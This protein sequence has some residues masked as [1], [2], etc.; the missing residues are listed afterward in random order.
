MRTA[1]FIFRKLRTGTDGKRST[2][3]VKVATAAVALSVAVMIAAISIVGG[4]KREIT[5]RIVGFNSHLTMYVASGDEEGNTLTLTPTLRTILDSIPYVTSYELQAAIPAVIKTPTDF[6][7]VYF[8]GAQD[9]DHLKF[10]GEN[11][12][13]GHLPSYTTNSKSGENSLEVLVSRKAASQLNLK[14]GDEIDTY[15][16][17]DKFQTR[18]LKIAGIYNTRF[19]DF[20]D[21]F[22]YGDIGLVQELVG[23]Q[24]N[25][26]SSMRIE[27]D[28]LDNVEYYAADLR[29]ILFTGLVTGRV[30]RQ[31]NIETVHARGAHYF[32]W[33]SLLDTNVAVILVLMTIVACITLVSGMLIIILDKIRFIGLMKALGAG[34]RLLRQVFI[35]LAIRIAAIGLVIGNALIIILLYV[36]DKTRFIPLDPD[37]YY[38]DFVP[39]ELNPIA[40]IGLNIAVLVVIAIVLL[41]PSAFVAKIAPAKTLH[42]E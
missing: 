31:Y 19:S 21:V 1:L 6:K 36:Q 35:L 9:A 38:I 27:T 17:S 39:V 26:G 30:S 29:N 33:L 14:A 20:D 23:L 22:I 8:K 3:A 42:G 10:I 24:P 37:S 7:G 5:N 32:Q 11:L 18:R 2:P 12:E 40:I 15:F 25:Q 13:E 34:N 28:D 41:V 16:I 4:F